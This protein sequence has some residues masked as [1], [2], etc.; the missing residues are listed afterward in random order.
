LEPSEDECK[1]GSGRTFVTR[2][3]VGIQG[4]ATLRSRQGKVLRVAT[5]GRWGRPG[6]GEVVR[7]GHGEIPREA[8]LNESTNAV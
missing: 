7:T 2:T 8:T 6:V 3:D 4:K 1:E 5:I